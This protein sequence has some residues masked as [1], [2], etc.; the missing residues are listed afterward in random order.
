MTAAIHGAGRAAG[1]Q[2]RHGNALSN[3]DRDAVREIAAYGGPFDRANPQQ[4]RGDAARRLQPHIHPW[5]DR[6]GAE[7]ACRR[8]ARVSDDGDLSGAETRPR[9]GPGETHAQEQQRE[10]RHERERP[11]PRTPAAATRGA[12]AFIHR[13]TNRSS[14][15]QTPSAST[16]PTTA[17]ARSR[18]SAGASPIATPIPARSIIGRSFQESPIAST[19]SIGIP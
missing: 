14:A 16:P 8:Y 9:S 19:R 3:H 10:K 18:T 7:N 17:F 13:K 1:D 12:L 11:D 6:C 4:A 15:S 2:P 5:V